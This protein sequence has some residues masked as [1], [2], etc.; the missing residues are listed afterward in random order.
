[1]A[2]L[3]SNIPSDSTERMRLLTKFVENNYEKVDKL[4]EIRDSA[5]VRLQSTDTEIAADKVRSF[6]SLSLV[7]NFRGWQASPDDNDDMDEDS[8]YLRRL[9]G[10]L[11]TLQIVDYILAWIVMED[12][13]VSVQ[14]LPKNWLSDPK[15]L[16]NRFEHMRYRCWRGGTRVW[17]IS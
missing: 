4:L 3:F 15:L 14:P 1:M 11:Y 6:R 16:Y 7:S 5:K 10:G 2:S 13:G 9:S 17:K 12:D 8:L